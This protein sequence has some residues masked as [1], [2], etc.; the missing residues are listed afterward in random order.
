MKAAEFSRIPRRGARR[1]CDPLLNQ[2]AHQLSGAYKIPR[3]FAD[4]QQKDF[5]G[6]DTHDER[7]W[8][9]LALNTLIARISVKSNHNRCEQEI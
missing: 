6:S 3:Q 9:R 2:A 7:P 1:R 4:Q 8:G 5:A